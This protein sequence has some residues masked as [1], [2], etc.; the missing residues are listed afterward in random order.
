MA[1]EAPM[2]QDTLNVP[3]WFSDFMLEF[4]RFREQNQREHGE[5]AREI[6]AAETRTTR[7][8]ALLVIDKL[9]MS[10]DRRCGVTLTPTLSQ[11]ERGRMYGPLPGG[12]GGQE[13]V[14]AVEPFGVYPRY[15][16]V[17]APAERA[18]RF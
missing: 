9:T 1:L 16:V 11:G 3:K 8:T 10:G 7:W 13:G 14:D 12:E 17:E 4:G 5:L 2:P 15:R 18:G 6:A